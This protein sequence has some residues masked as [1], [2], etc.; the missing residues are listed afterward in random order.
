MP[1]DEQ[2]KQTWIKVA[3]VFVLFVLA[4]VATPHFGLYARVAQLGK[5]HSLRLAKENELSEKRAKVAQLDD[6]RGRVAE[7]E[8]Q[9]A[10][11]EK[12][13]PNS[14]EAPELF[15]QLKQMAWQ[16][17]IRYTSFDRIEPVKHKMY[18][19]IPM[20]ISLVVDYH[21]LGAF[22]N[23]IENSDRFAKVD[24]IDIQTNTEDYTRQ[25]VE[26]NLSTFIFQSNSPEEIAESSGGSR[27]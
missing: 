18:T 4:M 16:T 2:E 3:V 12:R 1:M 24:N 10:Y 19:E 20:K 27:R 7:A 14:P 25:V 9:I 13:L 15:E 8:G 21:G 26:L 23:R 11:F 17:G 22:I 5:V 6:L